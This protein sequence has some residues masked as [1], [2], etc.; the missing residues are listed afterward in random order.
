[1]GKVRKSSLSPSSLP[2]SEE[3]MSITN[4]SRSEDMTQD[5]MGDVSREQA[6]PTEFIVPLNKSLR[7]SEPPSAEW[8]ALRAITHAGAD[9]PYE[10]PSSEMDEDEPIAD[11]RST[12]LGEEDM[13][14][15]EAETRLR[16]MR[17]SLGL[18]AVVQE[19]S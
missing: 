16:R 4:H 14:L 1:M 15:T 2:Q 7:K 11:E 19:D 10:P 18:T 3:D 6:E 9:G 13:D 17:E 5:S 8:L 12:R